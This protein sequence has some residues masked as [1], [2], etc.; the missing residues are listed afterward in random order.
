M[1]QLS[2]GGYTVVI[3]GRLTVK[4]W[5]DNNA[6]VVSPDP[7]VAVH[8]VRRAF[9]HCGHFVRSENDI[10]CERDRLRVQA[11][12]RQSGRE[13][14]NCDRLVSVNRSI[15]LAVRGT[16]SGTG[17]KDAVSRHR[18]LKYFTAGYSRS[19][20]P[21]I[22]LQNNTHPPTH[23]PTPTEIR[24]FLFRWTAAHTRHL[25]DAPTLY[26]I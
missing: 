16:G 17:E 9:S 1:C 19:R 22:P 25:H 2:V 4:W 18:V 11:R 5:Y 8:Y 21:S 6:V 13:R 15:L 7:A 3:A 10:V 24:Q 26:S 12:E 14:E 23:P 20:R